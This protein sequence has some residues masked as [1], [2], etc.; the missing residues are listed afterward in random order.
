M[1][2]IIMDYSKEKQRFSWLKVENRSS[3]VQL[4][5]GVLLVFKSH[6]WNF[7]RAILH[8]NKL[9]NVTLTLRICG[10][11]GFIEPESKLYQSS[12]NPGIPKLLFVHYSVLD[13]LGTI[14][15]SLH[16]M[17]NLKHSLRLSK[18]RRASTLQSSR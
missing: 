3:N 18:A 4:Y 12:I 8:L 10:F 9:I 7:E 14:L 15:Q 13:L 6:F 11:L 1:K 5:F 17:M 16:S 2:L